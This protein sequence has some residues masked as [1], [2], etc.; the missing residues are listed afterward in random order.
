V[1]KY[2]SSNAF[3]KKMN[4]GDIRNKLKNLAE[5]ITVMDV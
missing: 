3:I 2:N 5:N 4:E 1:D